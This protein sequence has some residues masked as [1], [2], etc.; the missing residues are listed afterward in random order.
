MLVKLF[1][2]IEGLPPIRREAFRLIYNIQALTLIPRIVFCTAVM[3]IFFSVFLTIIHWIYDLNFFCLSA[4]RFFSRATCR[5]LLYSPYVHSAVTGDNE[6]LSICYNR[7]EI[8]VT[9][10]TYI[11]LLIFR[12]FK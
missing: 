9:L 4:F 11:Y 8:V 5:I 7:D 3:D 2:G 1:W 10:I 12:L 6:C